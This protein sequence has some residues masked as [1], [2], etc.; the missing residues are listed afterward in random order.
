MPYVTAVPCWDGAACRRAGDDAGFGIASGAF[1]AA[2]VRGADRLPET[3]S[4]DVLGGWES[5]ARDMAWK[6]PQAPVT[7]AITIVEGPGTDGV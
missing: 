2:S 3:A 7:G 5:M 6:C 4:R 1:A